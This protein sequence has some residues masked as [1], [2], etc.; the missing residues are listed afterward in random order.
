MRTSLPSSSEH[1]TRLR[2]PRLWPTRPTSAGRS[3]NARPT[4]W[5][6]SKPKN[7]R[8]RIGWTAPR[9]EAKAL[10]AASRAAKAQALAQ[11][12]R[13]AQVE[14]AL[15]RTVLKAPFAGVV[16]E[17]NAEL[18]EFVTPSPTGIPTPP[19]IDLIDGSS[20]Y[21][22]APIDEVDAPAVRPGMQVRV[23][24]DA[25]SGRVFSGKVRRVA[26]Y[27][28]DREKQAR[29][30]DVEVDL[31]ARPSDDVLLPGYS[32]DVEVILETRENVVRVPTDTVLQGVSCAG[33]RRRLP[34]TRRASHRSRRRRELAVH[35]SPRRRRRGRTNR[36][37]GR[38]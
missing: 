3:H 2:A 28:L 7:W 5:R 38:P 18:G 20:L 37:H 23:K 8:R 29:T 13:I 19:T 9:S 34:D 17:V 11:K 32:A 25:F 36:D 30:V 27:V 10:Q 24:L 14:A 33:L 4:D 35:G 16:A 21:V 15:Q 22:K 31:G 1:A 12:A 6:S 26:P